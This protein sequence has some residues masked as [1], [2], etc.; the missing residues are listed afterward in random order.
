MKPI[1]LKFN[2]STTVQFWPFEGYQEG[3][4]YSVI[5]YERKD[6]KWI[7]SMSDN[8]NFQP[9]C[10]FSFYRRFFHEVK[11]QLITFDEENGT[12]VI[13][14]D[15]FDPA[16]KD[17]KV[18]IDTQ[19]RHE[20]FV[21]IEQAIE[22]GEKWNCRIT[23]ECLSDIAERAMPIYSNVEFNAPKDFYA[24]YHIGRY[25]MKEEGIN[26]FGAQSQSKG[27]ISGGFKF[28]RSFANPRDWKFLHSEQ[29]ARDILGLSDTQAWSQRYVDANWFI[30]TL[31]I[32]DDKF[33]IR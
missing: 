13:A 27:W 33:D 1:E 15:W 20:A 3:E 19:D 21:W 29:I 12:R 4:K 6:G 31:Q 16:G 7:E 22:F 11:A 9:Y 30:N 10:W 25:D 28:F 23:I 14:E 24:T 32:K 18:C 8:M 17:V 2:S 26:K 5:F